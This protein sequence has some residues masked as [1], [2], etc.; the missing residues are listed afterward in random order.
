[1][2][3]SKVYVRDQTRHYW[4]RNSGLWLLA[5]VLAVS[6]LVSLYEIG[7]HRGYQRILEQ[8]QR[9]ADYELALQ[10][11]ILESRLE[12]YR[13]L[14]VLIGRH[15]DQGH[16]LPDLVDGN[17]A[18]VWLRQL[19]YLSG[20][21]NVLLLA[22]D[23]HIIASA[24][25]A[26]ASLPASDLRKLAL[27]PLQGVL[28]RQ[29]IYVDG[30]TQLYGFSSAL[31][32]DD[33]DLGVLVFLL[34]LAPVFQS[35]TL[36]A[37]DIIAQD[38][39]HLVTL[40]SEQQWIGQPA[41][42]LDHFTDRTAYARAAVQVNTIGW[43][44]SV[45]E[46]VDETALIQQS[47]LS[48]VVLCLVIVMLFVLLI[49][50]RE[51]QIQ[52]ILRDKI[53]AAELERQIKHRTVELQ[54][55]NLHLTQ[56]VHD[57][58]QAEQQLKTTQQELIHSAKLAAIGQMSTTL[59]HEYNQPLATMRTYA[60]NALRLLKLDKISTAEDNLQRI[61]AQTDRLGNL[62]KVLMSF[63]RKP[64]SDFTRVDLSA[65]VEEAIMLVQP[66]NKNRAIAL[67]HQVG[68]GLFVLGNGVQ[69]SQILL[70]LLTNAIDAIQSRDAGP[71]RDSIILSA[72]GD[73]DRLILTIEDS[74]PGIDPDLAAVVFEPFM[75]TKE[76]GR[77]LGL[78][79][80][81]VKDIINDH[82]GEL[83]LSRAS[84]GG[85]R[86]DISLQ[87][88]ANK[89]HSSNLAQGPLTHEQ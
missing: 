16:W 47:L 88:W 7:Y 76:S 6:A 56:E 31:Q 49:R 10:V 57:R 79:L 32:I 24:Q 81:V 3:A 51:Q 40:S 72:A 22:E 87:C 53:Y 29:Y 63:A 17:V 68:E 21:Q 58:R 36:S 46:P 64:A 89:P 15:G 71:E 61:I 55:A 52:A 23:G 19:R 28:G 26:E 25:D 30:E 43:S 48:A 80:S 73:G 8:A 2:T 12:K 86:F 33:A 35:W 59:S 69:I 60:E 67:T 78:G 39:N 83:R 37:S 82:Q 62:S 18:S 9:Q 75:T 66:R 44:V 42:Q 34:D 14:P 1:M 4:Q 70:N 38:A 50:R 13:L 54:A 74:G 77:G 11:Q 45:Y 41:D 27:A 85:A 20:A 84:T 65:C 5:A